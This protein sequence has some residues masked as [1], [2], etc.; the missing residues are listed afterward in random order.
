MLA[1]IRAYFRRERERQQQPSMAAHA[2]FIDDVYNRRF[3]GADKSRFALLWCEIAEACKLPVNALHEDDELSERCPRS[4]SL[5][6][7]EHRLEDLEYLITMES[8]G[9]PPPQKTFKTI[10]DV[11]DYLLEPVEGSE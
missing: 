1:R 7:S 2:A 11:V 8:R 10:G 3:A 9:K 5:L 4:G 6:S